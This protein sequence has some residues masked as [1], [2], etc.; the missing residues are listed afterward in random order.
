MIFKWARQITV[1]FSFIFIHSANLP[2]ELDV[3]DR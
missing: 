2:L 1:I 3:S